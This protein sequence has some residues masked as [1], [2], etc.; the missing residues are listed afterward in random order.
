MYQGLHNGKPL[1]PEEDSPDKALQNI[2][3][4]RDNCPFDI[5]TKLSVKDLDT[6]KETT[7]LPPDKKIK[8]KK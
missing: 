6:G 8:E 7:V 5:S 3:Y 2:R 1:G 4:I